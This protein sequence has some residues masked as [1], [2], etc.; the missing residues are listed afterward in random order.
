MLFECRKHVRALWGSVKCAAGAG[1]WRSPEG[2]KCKVQ[3]V[4]GK[5]SATALSY[6]TPDSNSPCRAGSGCTL[7]FTHFAFYK[8]LT[9]R[10]GARGARSGRPP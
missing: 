3:L 8:N 5:W 9:Q 1:C 2:G 4:W 6:M 10:A 7:S